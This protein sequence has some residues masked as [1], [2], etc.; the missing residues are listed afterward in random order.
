[1]IPS[2]IPSSSRRARQYVAPRTCFKTNLILA[3]R[4]QTIFYLNNECLGY[5]ENGIIGN[6]ILNCYLDENSITPDLKKIIDL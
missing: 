4:P 2:H 6:L 5:I 1:M 3:C